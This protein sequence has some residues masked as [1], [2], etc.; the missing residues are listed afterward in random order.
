MYKFMFSFLILATALG[1]TLS[2]EAVTATSNRVTIKFADPKEYYVP[3]GLVWGA[4]SVAAA[5]EA[6]DFEKKE[7]LHEI[8]HLKEAGAVELKKIPLSNE[9][10][11]YKDWETYVSK[12]G[13][14]KIMGLDENGNSVGYSQYLPSDYVNLAT[15]LITLR[16]DSCY[17]ETPQSD[18]TTKCS[19]TNP[20]PEK[21][22]RA[23][24][25]TGLDHDMLGNNIYWIRTQLNYCLNHESKLQIR[26]NVLSCPGNRK[27]FSTSSIKLKGQFLTRSYTIQVNVSKKKA[28]MIV[29]KRDFKKV[30][31]TAVFQG[32]DVIR[33]G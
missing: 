21:Y 28:L 14:Y 7:I 24:L 31:K 15:F 5:N 32:S 1:P 26:N 30:A 12:Y 8:Q 23:A 19:L 16:Q 2:S 13:Q 6:M 27:P 10:L 3:D 17:L 11:Y 22:L 29:S 20:K 9:F 4:K 33:F 18:V 25:R